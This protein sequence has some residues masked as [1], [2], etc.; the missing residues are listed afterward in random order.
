MEMNFATAV[1]QVMC[2]K[3]IQNTLTLSSDHHWLFSMIFT[4]SP[5]SNF[6]T[7]SVPEELEKG[8]GSLPKTKSE[9]SLKIGRVCP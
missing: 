4:T 5:I 7:A 3:R 2:K 1:F 6:Y 8:D 9:F